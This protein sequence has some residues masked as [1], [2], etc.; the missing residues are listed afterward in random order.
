MKRQGI[1]IIKDVFISI[2]I[3]ACI[4][5]ILAIILYD[6]IALGKVVPEA[7]EYVLTPEMQ[8]ELENTILADAEEVIIEYSIDASDLKKYEETKE[9]VKGNS[10]PFA[11]VTIVPEPENNTTT[12]NS[13]ASSSGK[14]NTGNSGFYEDDGTK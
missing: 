3:V 7:E 8:K 12:E 5:I 4:G 2:L 14:E 11:T 1:E 13:N 10:D 6:N 9:Y